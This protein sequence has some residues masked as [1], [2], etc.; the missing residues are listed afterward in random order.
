M[1][2]RDFEGLYICAEC[3]KRFPF[4]SRTVYNITDGKKRVYYCG[5]TCWRKNG[6][7]NKRLEVA[8]RKIRE[9]AQS[10]KR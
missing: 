5:Y 2:Q 6:G 7:G 10:G 1:S 9:V 3:G 8:A 4:S